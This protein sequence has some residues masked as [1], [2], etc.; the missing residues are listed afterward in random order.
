MEHRSGRPSGPSMRVT[1]E[2][3]SS[4]HPRHGRPSGSATTTVLR[5]NHSDAN[6][7]GVRQHPRELWVCRGGAR[8]SLRVGESQGQVEVRLSTPDHQ[9]DSRSAWTND[10]TSQRLGRGHH[11]R[12]DAITTPLTQRATSVAPGVQRAGRRPVRLHRSVGTRGRRLLQSESPDQGRHSP[13]FQ[14]TPVDASERSAFATPRCS[15]SSRRQRG[16]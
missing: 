2:S 10:W 3:D 14:P 16:W 15:S 1:G 11:A 6:G 7:R 5:C 9:H 13:P 4:R 12:P 8:G